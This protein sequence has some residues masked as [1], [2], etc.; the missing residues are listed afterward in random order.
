MG[1]SHHITQRRNYRQPVFE[2]EADYLQYLQWLREY[3]KKYFLEIWA[4]CLMSN[5]VHFVGVP[6]KDDPL[7]RTFNT[8]YIRYSQYFTQKRKATGHLWQGR[9]YPCILNE[10]HSYAAIRYVENNPVRAM[11]KMDICLQKKRGI[12][13]SPSC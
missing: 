6:M 4:Y 10:R 2:P 11:P 1:Y 7:A 9:F 13:N 12:Y 8:L 3:C 5:H